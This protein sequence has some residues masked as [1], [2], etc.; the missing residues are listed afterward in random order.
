M[1]DRRLDPLGP[2]EIGRKRPIYAR[3]AELLDCSTDHIKLKTENCPL[4]PL[5]SR[6]PE[7][8]NRI[9]FRSGVGGINAEDQADKD[10]ESERDR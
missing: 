2:D 10:G 5:R 8:L 3:P 9:E 4:P 1:G 7:G 6:V